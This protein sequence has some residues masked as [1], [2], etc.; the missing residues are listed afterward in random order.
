MRVIAFTTANPT[1][2]TTAVVNITVSRNENGPVF[3]QSVYST[4]AMES[5]SL[6]AIVIVV[7]ATDLDNV[8]ELQVY[9]RP[10]CS[11]LAIFII[12]ITTITLLLYGC[13]HLFFFN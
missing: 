13:C 8:R 10:V 4:D 5:M 7:N 12:S 11:R 3:V 6:G 9:F 1:Q 2:Q